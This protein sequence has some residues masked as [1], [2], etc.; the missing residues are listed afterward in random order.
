MNARTLAAA[1]AAVALAAPAAG[2]AH[3]IPLKHPAHPGKRVVKHTVA[4]RL[5]CI[6]VTGIASQPAASEAQLEAQVD[7]ELIADGLAPIYG[8]TTTAT[9]AAT[10]VG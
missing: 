2:A 5:L 3:V 8:T 9:I 7:Q 4:P 6:C 10:S 1:L